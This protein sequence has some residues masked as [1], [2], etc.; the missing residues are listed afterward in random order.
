MKIPI[1][2]FSSSGNTKYIAKLIKNG[3]ILSNLEPE[4]IPINSLRRALDQI[5]KEYQRRLF[6]K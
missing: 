5:L 4:L 3:L 6:T 2:Y 1:I